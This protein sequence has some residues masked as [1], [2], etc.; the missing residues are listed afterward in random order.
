[1]DEPFWR[2]NP[3]SAEFDRNDDVKAAPNE[4]DTVFRP[5]SDQGPARD[6]FS[7]PGFLQELSLEKIILSPGLEAVDKIVDRV[8]FQ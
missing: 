8:F 5:Q 4:Q 6:L 7:L 3:G 2:Q 1:M